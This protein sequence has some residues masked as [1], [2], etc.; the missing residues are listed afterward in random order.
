MTLYYVTQVNFDEI[1]FFMLGAVGEGTYV[2]GAGIAPLF[3]NKENAETLCHNLTEEFMHYEDPSRY[4]AA[5]GLISAE[6]RKMLRNCPVTETRP[7]YYNM[8]TRIM[9]QNAHIRPFRV[10][11]ANVV[12]MNMVTIEEVIKE[13]RKISI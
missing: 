7:L 2:D 10:K 6:E 1:S 11:E 9:A 8:W 4:S 3:T 12:D 13:E 5:Y